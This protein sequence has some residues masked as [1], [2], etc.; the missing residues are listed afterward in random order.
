VIARCF[1]NVGWVGQEQRPD[2]EIPM[3]LQ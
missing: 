2:Q 3:A 1:A